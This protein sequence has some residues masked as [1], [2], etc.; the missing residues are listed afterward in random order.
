MQLYVAKPNLIIIDEP[1]LS[2]HPSAQRSLLNVIAEYSQNRQIVLSTH[3]PYLIKWEHL[4]NGAVLNRVVKEDDIHSQVFSIPD[5]T[6]HSKMVRTANWQMPFMMDEVAKEV[7]FM[8]DG[9]LFLEGQEDVGLLRKEPE[10]K[11]IDMF[12]Y[13]V[14]GASNFEFALSLAKDLGYK[15]VA[16]IL[17]NGAAETKIKADLDAKFPDFKIVQWNKSDIRDK[18]FTTPAPKEG[19][20]DASGKKKAPNDLDDFDQKIAEIKTHLS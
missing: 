7:F 18:T 5:F 6:K 2:L 11:N 19:Y 10:L 1:E 9:L 12:G 8:A 15:K 20:F 16:C 14:R 3:S 4:E 13:G 17:D